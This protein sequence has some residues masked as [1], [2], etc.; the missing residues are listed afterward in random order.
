MFFK[1]KDKQRLPKYFEEVATQKRII[2]NEKTSA[3]QL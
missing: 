3:T 1:R 2:C